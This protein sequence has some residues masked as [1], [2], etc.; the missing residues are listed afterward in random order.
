M[1]GKLHF[2]CIIYILN[3]F[4]DVYDLIK[5]DT[6]MLNKKN[7]ILIA[8]NIYSFVYVDTQKIIYNNIC[9]IDPLNNNIIYLTMYTWLSNRNIYFSLHITM[10]IYVNELFNEKLNNLIKSKPNLIKKI[11][12]NNLTTKKSSL[13]KYLLIN[14]DYIY[15]VYSEMQFLIIKNNTRLYCINTIYSINTINYII[16]NNFNH[17]QIIKICINYISINTINFN[18]LTNLNTIEIKSDKLLSIDLSE[19]LLL[20]NITLNCYELQTINLGTTKIILLSLMTSKFISIISNLENLT[21]LTLRIK[22]TPDNKPNINN[23]LIN[24]PN[25][26]NLIFDVIY[27]DILNA[28][29]INNLHLNKFQKI[30]SIEICSNNLIQ[31]DISMCKYLKKINVEYP[32]FCTTNNIDNYQMFTSTMSNI[33]ELTLNILNSYII[34]DIIKNYNNLLSLELINNS[35]FMLDLNQFT[36]LKNIKIISKH[37]Q[38]LNISKCIYLEKIDLLCNDLINIVHDDLLYLQIIILNIN[39]SQRI[40]LYQLI[41]KLISN[42]NEL[43]ILKYYVSECCYYYFNKVNNSLEM[44][45]R[46]YDDNFMDI[47]NKLD[48]SDNCAII[49][50]AHCSNINFILNILSQY[51]NIKTLK[52]NMEYQHDMYVKLDLNKLHN[53]LELFIDGNYSNVSTI[54]LDNCTNI[55]LIKINKYEEYFK[56]NIKLITPGYKI[57]YVSQPKTINIR[58]ILKFK[59]FA[60]RLTIKEIYITTESYSLNDKSYLSNN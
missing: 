52:L 39:T 33:E 60:F 23:I 19:C 37:L 40:N 24:C 9:N 34:F 32:Y 50:C 42:C 48:L 47:M 58:W 2:N 10:N 46:Y 15:A 57:L 59:K 14:N 18:K 56:F 7:R 8:N 4:L 11:Y 21:N 5:F 20:V 22:I 27:T 43:T 55:K 28:N 25:L 51:F 30:Q 36:K 6:S 31:V 41:K 17:L 1:I 54:K 44:C 3:S 29:Y 13:P 38:T 12:E 53:L 26:L 16:N 45:I 49:L 35:I